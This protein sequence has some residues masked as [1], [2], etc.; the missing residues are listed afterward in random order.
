M[1]SLQTSIQLIFDIA[2]L[3]VFA[4]AAYIGLRKKMLYQTLSTLIFIIGIAFF[5]YISTVISRYIRE[6]IAVINGMTHYVFALLFVVALSGAHYLGGIT[7]KKRHNKKT[8]VRILAMLA[9]LVKYAYVLSII[10]LYYA[11]FLYHI[12]NQYQ[13]GVIYQFVKTLAP[14]TIQ[15]LSFL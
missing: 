14:R 5:G 13:G 3:I 8:P 10:L 1:S 2:I 11:Y 15:T 7:G 6:H 4:Y 9:S 12:E